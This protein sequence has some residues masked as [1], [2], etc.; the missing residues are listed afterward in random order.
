MAYDPGPLPEPWAPD[1][2]RVLF[3]RVVDDIITKIETGEL[4]PN[5][6]LPSARKM[7]DQYGVGVMTIQRALRELQ[8]MKVTYSVAGR[9]TFIYPD[10]ADMRTDAP[11]RKTVEDTATLRQI[12]DY[13]RQQQ[14]ILATHG[15]TARDKTAAG[16]Q[17]YDLAH[18][19]RDLLDRITQAMIDVNDG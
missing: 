5:A 15:T 6:R 16:R 1:D 10:F 18:A 2:P 12:G 13:L 3:Q 17:L 11:L 7:A 4:H 9:G 14:A 8:Q 19:H